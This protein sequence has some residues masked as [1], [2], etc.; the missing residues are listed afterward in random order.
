MMTHAYDELYIRRTSKTVGLLFHKAV[1]EFNMDPDSFMEEFLRSHISR[2]IESGNPKY[3]AGMSASELFIEILGSAGYLLASDSKPIDTPMELYSYSDAYWAGWALCHFQWYYDLR[4]REII[5]SIS[6]SSLISL[7]QPLHE[8]DITKVY[9]ELL[10]YIK[11]RGSKL[12]FIRT[13][14]KITQEELSKLSGVSL[15]TIRSYEQG[16]KDIKKASIEILSKLA[17]ALKCSVQDIV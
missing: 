1:Q 11:D 3:M 4:F 12:R 2:E 9:E 16:T 10:T 14:C 15:N 8:A 6:F 7:Y 13:R 5:D 17:H